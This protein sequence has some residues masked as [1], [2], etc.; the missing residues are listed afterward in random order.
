MVELPQKLKVNYGLTNK[1]SFSKTSGNC[2]STSS[3]NLNLWTAKPTNEK[4]QK[5]FI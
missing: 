2:P 4:N 3:S 5:V 1:T